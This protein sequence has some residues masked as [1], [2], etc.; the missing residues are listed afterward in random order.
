MPKPEH[1]FPITAEMRQQ[2]IETL[3]EIVETGTP[4]EQIEACRVLIEAD[5]LNLESENTGWLGKPSRN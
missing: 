3:M 4:S 2:C 1:P 5:A